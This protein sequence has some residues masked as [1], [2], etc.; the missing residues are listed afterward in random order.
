LLVDLTG[1]ALEAWKPGE[2]VDLVSVT[3]KI[4]S[5][6]H[7]RALL[8]MDESEGVTG[9]LDHLQDVYLRRFHLGVL[10]PDFPLSPRRRAIGRAEDLSNALD[11]IIE[12]R[13]ASNSAGED[14]FSMLLAAHDEDGSGLDDDEV[15]GLL[16]ST[17]FAAYDTTIHSIATAA[18]LLAQHPKVAA[19]L[20]EE[21]ATLGGAPPTVEQLERLPFLE[22][23]I[24]ET[25]RIVPAA[26]F[27]G[28]TALE[29]QELGGYEIPPKT[30][31]LMSIY[32]MHR[33][34]EIYAEPNRFIPERWSSIKPGPYE[35][36]P[37]SVG[38]HM[39]TGWALALLEM[40]VMLAIFVQRFRLEV[41][42]GVR[43][44]WR[45]VPTIGF[46]NGLPMRVHVQD[47]N[48]A[49]RRATPPGTF[50]KMIRIV[51]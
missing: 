20:H 2:Q 34:P 18:Y 48:Y 12:K 42:D 4:L 21:L 5:L 26:P 10:L 51:T 16:A 1:R 7:G 9:L 40:K 32:H 11:K 41:P 29:T 22:G 47:G 46:K 44:D 13:R 36:L 14:L 43:L 45:L 33:L 19:C 49:E 25:L 3:G 23:V 50:A 30:E 31:L 38:P 27:V 35:Y 39:C 37:F 17:V 8:G 6:F 15:V 24:K 28:R